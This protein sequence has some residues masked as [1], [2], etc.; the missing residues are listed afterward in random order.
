ME[1]GR[2]LYGERTDSGTRELLFRGFD[3]SVNFQGRARDE[4]TNG[5]KSEE[6]HPFPVE[7][8]P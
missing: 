6:R 7:S 5:K 4:E 8:T 1:E 2:P 3:P